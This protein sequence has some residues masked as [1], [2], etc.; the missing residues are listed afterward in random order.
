MKKKEIFTTDFLPNKQEKLFSYDQ[1]FNTPILLEAGAA[2]REAP[3]FNNNTFRKEQLFLHP[4]QFNNAKLCHPV[5]LAGP[6]GSIRGV[7]TID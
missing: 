2:R 6:S 1:Y 7:L 4:V 5:R 3:Q